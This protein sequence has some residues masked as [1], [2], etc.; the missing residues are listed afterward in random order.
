MKPSPLFTI[1]ILISI[2]FFSS[3][4][5]KVEDNTLILK[6]ELKDKGVSFYDLFERIDLIPLELNDSSFIKQIRKI[7]L[8][9]DTLYVLDRELNSIIKFDA[10]SGNHINT[11]QKVGQGPGEYT[12]LYD[13]IVNSNHKEI[14]LLSPF[15]F[16]NRYDLS[17][18]FIERINLPLPDNSASAH[19]KHFDDITYLLWVNSGP[20]S[21]IGKI[22]L[23]SKET[24]QIVNSFWKG[25]GMEDQF[26]VSPFWQY[27]GKTY[28]STSIT[29]NV[30]EIT[31]D[32]TTLAY[33]WDF[34]E[35]DIDAFREKEVAAPVELK[36]TTERMWQLVEQMTASDKLYRF[37]SRHENDKYC[38][39]QIVFKNEKNL[40]P[41]IFYNKATGEN[42][43][44]FK[45]TEGLLFITYLFAE[46][47]IVAELLTEELETLLASSLLNEEQRAIL[48]K[49]REDDN[50]ILI[51]L[52]FKLL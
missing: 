46:D 22:V 50:P 13:A 29:N 27:Q 14:E 5:T 36:N 26:V 28:F 2:L 25:Q 42:L 45:T 20:D 40:V 38:Y 37:N 21:D 16:I 15:N 11:I 23:I 43:Y 17:G 18:C 51:K 3:C 33:K 39:A 47:C 32:G 8:V 6:V 48:Q 41:H 1:L 12:H 44:F 4:T 34:G 19:F 30:Y 52:H 9:N 35:Y 49:R 24:N 10:N 7:H 31:P